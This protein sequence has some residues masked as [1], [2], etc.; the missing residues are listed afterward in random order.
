MPSTVCGLTTVSATNLAGTL[1][2]AAQ[3]N[4]TSLGDLTSLC[5][6]G[7]TVVGGD[8]TIAGDDLTMGT[9]TDGYILVAD[10][11]NYNPVAVSGDVTL[12]NAGAITIA[13]GAVENSMLANCTV[14]YGGIQLV[15]G[16]TDA[17]PAFDLTDATN[18]PT[19]SLVGTITNAQLAGSIANSKLANDSVSFGGVSV[20]L[21]ASD[22]TPAFD[23]SDATAYTGDSSLV[24]VGTISS[25]T[26]QGT[27]IA[28]GYIAGT[29]TS[30]TLCDPV[31]VGTISAVSYT[32]LTLPTIYSV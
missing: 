8:L 7:D 18:Y 24:T 17:T 19:S 6:T 29:L 12:S 13:A 9:N 4:V 2:T 25:G 31:L 1:S 26:W 14:S 3:G 23:L 5:V 15:L 16:G 10:G 32:H 28:T 27:A 11:T 22:A 21:G 20:D 30:K